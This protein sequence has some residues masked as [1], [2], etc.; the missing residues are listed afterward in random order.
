MRLLA[1]HMVE[2]G[3]VDALS[4]ETMRRTLKKTA[5]SPISNASG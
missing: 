4:H 2:L 1:D 3:Y 5:S